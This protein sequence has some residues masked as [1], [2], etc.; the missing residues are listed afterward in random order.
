MR[1]LL[2]LAVFTGA[3]FLGYYAYQEI[4]FRDG[5]RQVHDQFKSYVDGV[6]VHTVELKEERDRLATDFSYYE[7]LAREE[8]GM[9][10]DSEVVFLVTVPKRPPK[11]P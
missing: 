3:G 6:E 7:Q 9:V 5:V 8:L 2:I 4:L 11:T 10:K 1:K